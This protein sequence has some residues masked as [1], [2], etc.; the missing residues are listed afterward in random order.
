M[1]PCDSVWGRQKLS[2]ERD[3]AVS[4][5]ALQLCHTPHL[6]PGNYKKL[7]V[8]DISSAP[9][10][11][12]ALVC[13]ALWHACLKWYSADGVTESVHKQ[14]FLLMVHPCGKPSKSV[15]GYLGCCYFSI[16]NHIYAWLCRIGVGVSLHSLGLSREPSFPCREWT[17][18]QCACCNT[19]CPSFH[20]TCLG[21]SGRLSPSFISETGLTSLHTGCWETHL[22]KGRSSECLVWT[23][24]Q[25]P[26]YWFFL[27]YCGEEQ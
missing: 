2:P 14:K 24:Y 4:Q 27:M 19:W 20:S 15:S 8:S 12:A 7:K 21:G 26:H 1:D 25:V 16:S 5:L 6:M 17:E 3:S 18:Y 9:R 22:L 10:D 13:L 11:L 23:A